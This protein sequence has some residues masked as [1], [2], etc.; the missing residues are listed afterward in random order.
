MKIYIAE[1][2]PLAAAKL[3]LFLEKLGEGQDVSTFDNGISV[4]AAIDRELPDLLFL[5]IQMPGMSGMEVLQRT[6]GL[7]VIITSAYDQY[8]IDSYNLNVTDYLLKP[9]TLDRLKSAIDKGKKI[10][11]LNQLDEQDKGLLI[12]IRVDGSTEKFNS[13]E[14][15]YFESLK[16][17][18]KVVM[19]NNR[20]RLTL[21][22]LNGF[23]EQLSNVSFIRVHRSYLI[24]SQKIASQSAASFIMADGKEI[25]IGR[26]YKQNLY[27]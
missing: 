25:P 23:E 13:S 1:D 3:K 9:Y 19:T 10:I 22:R 20:T 24:N 21:G 27:I 17:Y 18:V 12:T 6:Q 26:K 8:A 11:R 5:D 2:E 14:I 15:L 16:D 4:L 7:P